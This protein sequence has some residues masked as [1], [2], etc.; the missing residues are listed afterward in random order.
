MTERPSAPATVRNRDA[1][2]EV[3]SHELRDR[4][5]LFEIG[6]G[7][8]QHA[9]YIAG[10]LRD[11]TWQTS[12]RVQNHATINAWIESEDVTNVLAPLVYDVEAP[13]PMDGSY[14]AVFS[15]NTAHIMSLHAVHCMFALVGN[16]LRAGGIFCLYGPFNRDGEFTSD[17]NAQF[18]A[19]LRSQDPLMGIRNLE[20]L[21]VLAQKAGMQRGRLYAMPANNFMVIWHRD[22]TG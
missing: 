19:S 20:D 18:D 22:D 8:G 21:D 11:L 5:V 14:D 16:L 6:S 10:Q 4:T 12:D 17:S 3:L 9:V 2:L 1:L 13:P 15:A 7:T